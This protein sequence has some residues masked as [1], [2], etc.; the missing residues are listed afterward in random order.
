VNVPLTSYV[1][2][3]VTIRFTVS[4]C[5]LGGHC[6]YAYVDASC[7]QFAITASSPSG[8][9]CGKHGY[10]TLSGPAGEKAYVWSGPSGGI[11]SNDTLQNINVDSLGKYK[12]IIT[13]LTGALCKDTLY[14][15]VKGRDTISNSA[16]VTATIN[17]YGAAGTALAKEANG[18]GAFTYAWTP[19]G[20]TN[21]TGTGL[22]AGS[23]TVTVEDTN[24]CVAS[25]V[26]V[27][28]QPTQVIAST[29]FTQATCGNSNGTATVSTIGGYT[30]YTYSWNPSAETTA[31]A[32][33]LKAGS[34][35]ITVTDKNHCTTTASVTVT[36]PS[37]VT[38]AIAKTTP[39]NCFGGNNGT[40]SVTGGGGNSP[41]TYAWTPKG[42]TTT[43]ATGLSAGGYTVTVKDSN[44]CTATAAATI[45]QPTLLKA[46]ISSINNIPC[47]GE[48]GSATATITGGTSPYTYLWAPS[49]GI[50]ATG[51]G[52]SAG[53]YII[54]VA[55]YNGCTATATVIMTQPAV[56]T[57][58]GS[59]TQASCNLPNG[60]ATASASGGTVPYAYLWTPSA[61]TAATATGLSIGTYTVNVTDKNHCTASITVTI[62]QPTL[63]TASISSVTNV[64]CYLGGNGTATAAGVGGTGPYTYLWTPSNY[65]N[66]HITGLFALSYLVIVTDANGCTATTAATLTQPEQ[67]TASI[68]EPRVICKDSTGVILANVSGGVEQY[69][70]AWSSGITSTTSSATL[71]PVATRDYSVT[72]T[73][74]NGCTATTN[75]VLQYG[76]SITLAMGGQTSICRGDSTT[77]C[78][79]S[80]G[81]TGGNVYLWNPV[82]STNSCIAVAPSSS[83]MY[84]VLV[85]DN[86]GATATV[87]TTVYATPTPAINFGADVS[88][89]CIPLCVQ[90]LNNTTLSQGKIRQYVWSFGNGDTVHTKNPIYCYSSSGSYNI[91]LTAISDSGCS[92]TLNISNLVQVYTPPKAAFIYSPQPASILTPTIQ[93]A[94]VSIDAYG[95][96]AYRW[97]NFGDGADSSSNLQDPSHTYGDTGTYCAS[98]IVMDSHGCMDTVTNCLIIEPQYNLYIPSAFT[99]NGDELNETFKPVGQYIKGF[100]MYIFDRWGM[101]LYH[102]TDITEGWNGSVHGGTICQED[103]Y[104]YKITVTDS[105]GIRHSYIGNVTLLK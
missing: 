37:A 86:C 84:S 103:T 104:V 90:F 41:Y 66:A 47:N 16:A 76:P 30:P 85:T 82:T 81:G 42:G 79:L 25:A 96:I 92:A 61:E 10:I 65:T 31:K 58:A 60:T 88:Q 43:L 1:G 18:F 48:T 98:L 70:Y 97:W 102:T 2:Q 34:Y 73:D 63:V 20:G 57:V 9:I 54:G 39:V 75:I 5:S 35:T 71:T 74:A 19:T 56:L 46:I 33:G 105:E 51:T 80:S 22:T 28:T 8:I 17:C 59:F 72:V 44:G 99:P 100:E 36:Q 101:E 49:G 83:E 11:I 26:V 93:F 94:D 21:A 55:D 78:V 62:T 91:S 53:A 52:L 6:G 29:S 38:A 15:T 24:A 89:G 69:K 23:Y 77:L 50:N 27:L 13:P 67:L 45:T 95:P 14:Y 64:S 4:D 40:A 68:S 12:L 7:S 32:T 87:A 3:C